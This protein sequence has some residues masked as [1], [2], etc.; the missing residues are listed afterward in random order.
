M[1]RLNGDSIAFLVDFTNHEGRTNLT[2]HDGSARTFF[3]TAC[4]PFKA[5]YGSFIYLPRGYAAAFMG[6]CVNN[7]LNQGFS[8]FQYYDGKGVRITGATAA[9]NKEAFGY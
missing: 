3:R 4:Y 1:R 9:Q 5:E 6:N 2:D 8:W 7:D